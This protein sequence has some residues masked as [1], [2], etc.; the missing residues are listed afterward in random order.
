MRQIIYFISALSLIV[1]ATGTVRAE[2]VA[3][4]Q[5]IV[6]MDC[7]FE[8]VNDGLGTL[9]YLTPEACG[10]IIPTPSTSPPPAVSSTS[11]TPAPEPL[12]NQT[13]TH[14]HPPR[15]IGSNNTV[16]GSGSDPVNVVL[17]NNIADALQ[18]GGD[19][20]PVHVGSTFF[21]RP[22]DSPQSG[23]R[24]LTITS[25]NASGITL[26]IQQLKL[27]FHLGVGQAR[28][29]DTLQ[30][31]Q[32]AIGIRLEILKQPNTATV[33]LQ[34]LAAHQTSN[35]PLSHVAPLA[36]AITVVFV[37]LGL[38]FKSGRFRH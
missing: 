16:N 34:L 12:V 9:H 37:T 5:Q 17:L 10:V 19:V 33:R 11:F 32:P 38:R 35:D 30:N 4:K 7:I 23:I 6:P 26:Y 13:V 20:F 24:S 3:L 18:S 25:I 15:V 27:S 1:L 14:D 22:V 29:Y 2:D 36:F 8:E 28:T 21:Y 31:G